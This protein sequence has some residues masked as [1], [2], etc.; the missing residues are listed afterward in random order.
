M[1]VDRPDLMFETDLVATRALPMRTLNSC[2]HVAM[3]MD[4]QPTVFR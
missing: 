1:M 2:T 3:E 4:Y